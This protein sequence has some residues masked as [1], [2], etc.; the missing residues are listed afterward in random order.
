MKDKEYYVSIIIPTFNREMYI[1]ACINS[2][3]LQTHQNFELIVVDDGSIDNTFEILSNHADDR[4][5]VVKRDNG[6]PSAAR[7]TGIKT[8]RYELIAFLDS[9]DLWH[10]ERL[11]RQIKMFKADKHLH[12]CY[13]DCFLFDGDFN[14]NSSLRKISQGTTMYGGNISK[15]LFLKGCFI[16]SPT[17]LLKR[18]LFDEFGLFCNRTASEDWQMWLNIASK[19]PICF[20]P[21]AL[22][23]YRVHD[24]N[25]TT[26]QSIE[27][28]LSQKIAVID[29]VASKFPLIYNEVR[30]L[31]IGNAYLSSSKACL[32]DG[33]NNLCRS[34]L[35]K[36]MQKNFKLKSLFYFAI[37]F[38]NR[39]F[40]NYAINARNWLLRK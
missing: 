35:V 24:N 20:I 25:L 5:K 32:R 40:F 6:G 37:S 3:L 2:I 9:D 1:E 13:S 33:F 30:N 18:K 22:A 16:P 11:S 8:A 14:N 23:Y 26:T 17:L 36:S 34:Y 7:N 29:G 4:L 19:Y 31:A 38:T 10:P 39:N 27:Y 21:D 28:K 12:W 15:E